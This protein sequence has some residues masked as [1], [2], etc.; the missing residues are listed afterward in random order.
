MILVC[1]KKLGLWRNVELQVGS[2]VDFRIRSVPE[3]IIRKNHLVLS[4]IRK[5][6]SG[7]LPFLIGALNWV[8]RL[9]L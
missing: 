5:F 4:R 3:F 1:A 8:Y 9:G 7:S 6:S 2:V